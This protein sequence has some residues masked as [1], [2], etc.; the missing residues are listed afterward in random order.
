VSNELFIELDDETPVSADEDEEADVAT[1]A[2]AAGAGRVAACAGRGAGAGVAP[3]GAAVSGGGGG[4]GSDGGAPVSMANEV[5]AP[6]VAT[7]TA[8]MKR[9][10][11]ITSPACSRI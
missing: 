7:P 11:R 4:G 1:V 5:D 3:G 9:P 6:R 10:P 8:A 2:E